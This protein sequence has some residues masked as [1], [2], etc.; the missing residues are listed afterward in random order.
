MN[1]E[2]D[3]PDLRDDD[4]RLS[5]WIDG[6]LD[7]AA[8]DEVQRAVRASPELSL[9][10]EELAHS[11]LQPTAGPHVFGTLSTYIEAGKAF[12]YCCLFEKSI[13]DL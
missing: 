3:A 8:A 9:L 4:P 5:E 13:V 7:P 2:T 11:A 6:R 10:V 12:I 1:D